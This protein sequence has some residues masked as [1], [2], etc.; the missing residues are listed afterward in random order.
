MPRAPATLFAWLRRE[1]RADGAFAA[2]LDADQDGEEGK[3]YVW[4]AAEIDAALGPAA[5]AFKAAYDVREGGNWEGRNVL[6][7]DEAGRRG[8]GAPRR[9]RRAAC[10][11]CARAAPG[12]AS[13][14]RFSPIGTA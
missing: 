5:A 13:T 2:S 1:M 6:R 3:F 10:S 12:P 7:H 8:A 4:T 14:T 9:R 11:R